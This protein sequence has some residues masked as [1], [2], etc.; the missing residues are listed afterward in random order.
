MVVPG[1]GQELGNQGLMGM[2]LQPWEDGS[3]LSVDGDCR[4]LGCARVLDGT[5]LHS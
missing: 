2:E 1:A 3:A 4:V 5:E